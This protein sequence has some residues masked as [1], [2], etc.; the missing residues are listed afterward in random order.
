MAFRQLFDP[1]TSTLTYILMDD[2]SKQAVIIDPVFGQE[3]RDLAEL[4][5]MGASLAYIAE[6]H[7]HADHITGAR[8]IKEATRCQ[9]ISGEGTGI[10]CGDKL[11]GDG[12][13]VTFGEETLH[14]IKT[15]GH[16]SGCTT[17]RWRDRLFTGDTLLIGGCGRT[18]FQQGD[19]GELFDSLQKLMTF[20]DET[21]VYPAHDYNGNRVSN[22]RQEKLT[23]DRIKG[24]SR[25]NF[26][27]NMN[28][29]N[30]PNPAKIDIAVPA[31][32]VCGNDDRGEL[33]TRVVE[34]AA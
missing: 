12:D 9:F 6:T 18:D 30:L 1:E 34:H 8:I 2:V 22:I 20:S 11:M 15:P 31:N 23:N 5:M 13:S 25:E 14:S 26:I 24:R 3:Q 27:E 19:A 28:S 7:V 17:Y 10:T 33:D 16:T 29:L 32:M 4:E 21:L